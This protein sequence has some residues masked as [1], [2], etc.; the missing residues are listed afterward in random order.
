MVIDVAC[1][2]V[3]GSAQ[4]PSTHRTL[5]FLWLPTDMVMFRLI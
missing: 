3:L 2:A 1:E 5:L 4:F